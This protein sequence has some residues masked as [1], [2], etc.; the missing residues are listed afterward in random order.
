MTNPCSQVK[1]VRTEG[2]VWEVVNM[3]DTGEASSVF[4]SVKQVDERNH[5]FTDIHACHPTHLDSQFKCVETRRE[6]ES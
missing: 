6:H 1:L 4:T 2:E 3:R 5:V